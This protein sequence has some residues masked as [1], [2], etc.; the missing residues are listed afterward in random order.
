MTLRDIY[1][2]FKD[3]RELLNFFDPKS[4][5]KNNYEACREIYNKMVDLSLEYECVFKKYKIGYIF[6][7]GSLLFSFCVKPEYRNRDG[8]AVFGELIKHELGDHFSCHL[9]NRNTRAIRFMERL[10]LKKIASDNL[11]TLLSI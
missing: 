10:G 8:L 11:I 7:S 5:A 2:Y 3:D 9:Y 4:R 1:E 6:Y